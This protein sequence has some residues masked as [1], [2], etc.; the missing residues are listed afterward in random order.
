MLDVFNIPGQQDNVKIFYASSGSNYWQ[1]WQK[2]RGC[3]F[4][5]MMAIGGGN[6][7]AGMSTSAIAEVN[8]GGSGAITRALFPANVLPD[9]LYVQ[10][11]VGGTGGASGAGSS[12]NGNIGGRSYV[13][14]VASSSDNMNI[15]CVSGTTPAAY[16]SAEGAA[17]PSNANLLSLG[18]YTSTAG[19]AGPTGADVTPF[20]ITLTCAGASNNVGN[21]AGRGIATS[22]LNPTISGGTIGGGNGNSGYWSWKPMFGIGGTSGGGNNAGTGGRGGDGG[23]GCGGG[24][25]GYGS[26]AGGAGG[27]GGNGLVIIVTF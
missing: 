26:V 22:F 11:G 9:I 1:T 15:V 13:S 5:W 19:Q 25:G 10:P 2:P 3:K 23:Y 8:G 20:S 24:T 4:I 7:G 6:G 21:L 14:I 18:T 12:N 27:N 17:S 16:N